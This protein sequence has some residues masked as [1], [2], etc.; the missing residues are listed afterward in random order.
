MASSCQQN[1]ME[2][3]VGGTCWFNAI[4]NGFL[5]SPKGRT[6]LRK[7][8]A[9]KAN[10]RNH[11]S[12][13]SYVHNKLGGQK[14]NNSYTTRYFKTYAAITCTSKF[15]I[16]SGMKY[17][18]IVGYLKTIFGDYIFNNY[19]KVK[20]IDIVYKN[21]LTNSIGSDDF[22]LSHSYI[23]T[24]NKHLIC[25]YT[26]EST[27]WTYDSGTA[28]HEQVDWKKPSD[29]FPIIYGIY[30]K[31]FNETVSNSGNIKRLSPVQVKFLKS[32]IHY[33]PNKPRNLMS[34][35]TP[36]SSLHK[37]Y[38]KWKK[39][40]QNVKKLFKYTEKNIWSARFAKMTPTNNNTR[41]VSNIHKKRHA[42]KQERIKILTN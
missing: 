37:E 33:S 14:P 18:D 25:G 42:A 13:W 35:Q 40:P 9:L 5:L 22:K 16:E 12:F 10:N 15:N 1:F 31:P 24:R 32:R 38:E 39:L 3:Q 6:F 8:M 11:A 27:Q 30:L 20:E 23:A 26:C 29:R 7:V 34:I 21:S 41:L 4:L 19:I 28:K 2:K 17:G 36:G